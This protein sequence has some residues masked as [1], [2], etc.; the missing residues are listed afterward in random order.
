M[1]GGKQLRGALTAS[2]LSILVTL[3][4]VLVTA[5]SGLDQRVLVQVL[6]LLGISATLT[7]LGFV[8]AHAYLQDLRSVKAELLAADLVERAIPRYVTFKKRLDVLTVQRNGDAT[9][10]WHF[11][12]ESRPED[13]ISEL[14]FPC[15]AETAPGKPEWTAIS[16]ASIRVNGVDQTTV[17]TFTPVERRIQVVGARGPQLIEYGLLRVPVQLEDGRR[18][19]EVKVV[20]DLSDVFPASDRL[21]TFYVDIPYIT[22]ELR[23]VVRGKD[24]PA[25]RSPHAPHA[26]TAES[27]LMT[28]NDP[29]E[30]IKQS[31]LCRQVGDELIWETTS[32][33]MSYR[34]KVSFR[35]DRR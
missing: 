1:S 23:V 16:V 14:S 7:A 22:E 26:V 29:T 8:Y 35:L 21:E 33:K 18:R 12:L 13:S 17:D 34:Y 32:P 24:V 5:R 2:L 25:L 20:L 30:A 9:L 19:S 31:P 11:V 3:L 27:G 4:T 28:T 15:F 6:V 10:E